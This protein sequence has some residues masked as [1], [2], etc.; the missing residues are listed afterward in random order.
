MLIRIQYTLLIKFIWNFGEGKTV[1]LRYTHKIYENRIL[2][3]LE[4]NDDLNE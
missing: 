3:G 2:A 4:K 1:C